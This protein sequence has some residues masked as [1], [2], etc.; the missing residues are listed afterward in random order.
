MVQARVH[1]RS[2]GAYG[3]LSIGATSS[4]KDRLRLSFAFLGLPNWGDFCS[5]EHPFPRCLPAGATKG[6][7]S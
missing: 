3:C 5:L 2:H 7:S 1:N 6:S 4:R